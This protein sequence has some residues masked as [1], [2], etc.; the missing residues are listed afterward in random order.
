VGVKDF[1]ERA[2]AV[3]FAIAKD[4]FFAENETALPFIKE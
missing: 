4:G 3:R 2:P 1:G